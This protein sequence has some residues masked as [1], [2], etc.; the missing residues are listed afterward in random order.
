MARILRGASAI[1]ESS[2]TVALACRKAVVLPLGEKSV[3]AFDSS[4]RRRFQRRRI[5]GGD[6]EQ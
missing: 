2:P 6:T 1:P 5:E 3:P 4:F